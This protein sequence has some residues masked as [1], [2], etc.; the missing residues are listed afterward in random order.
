MKSTALVIIAV[1]WLSLGSALAVTPQEMLA[2]PALEARARTIGQGLRCLVCQNQSI[3]DSNAELAHD[4]RVLVRERLVAGDSD[5]QVVR[6]IVDRYGQFVLLKPPVEPSTYL[7]WLSPVIVLVLGLAGVIAY[8]GRRRKDAAESAPLSEAERA[9]L[10][11][12]LDEGGK[13]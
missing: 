7:L 11:R 10:A 12:L 5:A 3:D 6:Y 1:L 13:R 9:L 2:D 4:L 8:L